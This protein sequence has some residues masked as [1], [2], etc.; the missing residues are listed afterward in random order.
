MSR[1]PLPT[2]LLRLV[3]LL[4]ILLAA[5]ASGS[6]GGSPSSPGRPLVLLLH[7]RGLQAQD[8]TGLRHSWRVA[9]DDGMERI[10]ASLRLDEEDLRL[11]WYADALDPRTTGDGCDGRPGAGRAS[12][13]P[14]GEVAAVMGVVG[15]LL[16]LAADWVGELEGI[17]LR[18]VA[19][20]LLYLGDTRKRCLAEERVAEA[21]A[22]A[23]RE[24][25][26]VILVAHSFGSL[27]AYSHLRTR[28]PADAV[29]VARLVTIGSLVGYPELR[30]LLL[31]P[32]GRGAALPPGV[33][34]WV[35]VR[36]PADPLSSPLVVPG[37]LGGEPGL[38]DRATESR[39]GA[40]PHDAARYLAD[41]A[42]ARAVL[43]SWCAALTPPVTAEVGCPTP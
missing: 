9:L 43:E 7:G 10:G 33:G 42:T 39:A 17:A 26:P 6:R 2:R 37:G 8:T 40:D 4:S 21:L 28:D 14:G 30:E 24:G 32:E 19:G 38:S 41:P 16:G 36:D 15:S 12:A 22:A 11:V 23:A 3:P 31:G 25:R 34:S 27:V 29:P 13:P 35:N 20:D 18:S 1:S 5:A